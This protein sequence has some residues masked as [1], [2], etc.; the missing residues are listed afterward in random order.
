[1]IEAGSATLLIYPGP[2]TW[3]TGEA[4][5]IRWFG[6]LGNLCFAILDS[7]KPTHCL[8]VSLRLW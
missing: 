6:A 5:V 2:Q 3:I 7:S 1:L 4:K 8:P